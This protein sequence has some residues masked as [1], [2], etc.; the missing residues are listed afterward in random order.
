MSSFTWKK[1]E[2]DL[3]EF[4]DIKSLIDSIS[5]H[6][7]LIEWIKPHDIQ[8]LSSILRELINLVIPYIQYLDG[9]DDRVSEYKTLHKI[10]ENFLNAIYKNYS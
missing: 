4:N 8:L 9:V 10:V 3:S 7:K 2:Y 6:Y 5:H 1:Q